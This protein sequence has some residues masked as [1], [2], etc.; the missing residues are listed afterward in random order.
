MSSIN[1]IPQTP[2]I[3]F[4]ESEIQNIIAIT[5]EYSAIYREIE[6]HRKKFNLRLIKFLGYPI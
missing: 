6:K 3:A 4:T 1:L 5:E 2:Q